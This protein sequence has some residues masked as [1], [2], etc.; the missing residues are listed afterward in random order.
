MSSWLMSLPKIA[1]IKWFLS[2]SNDGKLSSWST[3]ELRR[4]QICFY[5]TFNTSL[6]SFFLVI[7]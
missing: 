5:L 7:C 2:D 4:E 6:S 3:I 1:P